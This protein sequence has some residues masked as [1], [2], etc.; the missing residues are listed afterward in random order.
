MTTSKTF[1]PGDLLTASDV[2]QY[3]VNDSEEIDTAVSGI[4]ASINAIAKEVNTLEAELANVDTTQSPLVAFLIDSTTYDS[5]WAYNSDDVRIKYHEKTPDKQAWGA[6]FPQNVEIVA[7]IYD[8]VQCPAE[9]DT[10]GWDASLFQVNGT[11]V[12][13]L[14]FFRPRGF[15]TKAMVI[16]KIKGEQQ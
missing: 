14:G 13:G 5:S 4:E 16:Y 3:L 1:K 9:D 15:L 11:T 10:Y 8:Y 7:V 6:R 2:N 12:N